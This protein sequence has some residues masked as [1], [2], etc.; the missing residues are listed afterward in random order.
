PNPQSPSETEI[1]L[2]IKGG[3][4]VTT[5]TPKVAKPISKENIAK[6]LQQALKHYQAGRFAAAEQICRKIVQS[7]PQQADALHLLGILAYEQGNKPE[8]I[9]KYRQAI[10]IKPDNPDVYNNL[11]IALKNQGDLD[12]AIVYYQQAITLRPNSADL[13]KNLGLAYKEKGLSE[14]AAA[15]YQQAITIQP[16]QADL[17]NKL[18]MVYRELGLAEE[19]IVQYQQALKLKPNWE[20]LYNNLGNA[21][22]EKGDLASAKVAYHQAIAI[23]SNYAQAQFGLAGALLMEGDF[24]RGFQGYEWRWKLKDNS[25]RKF[26]QP[27]WD[28]SSLAG[29]TILLHAEQGLGDTIQFIRY[30][31]RLKAQGARVV[32]ETQNALVELFQVLDDIDEVVGRGKPLPDFDV[33]SPLLSLSRVFG[34]TIDTIPTQVPYL[35]SPADNQL[36]LPNYFSEKNTVND[37]NLREQI[38]VNDL[39]L[40]GQ[41]SVN[42]IN[43]TEE[44]SV[45]NINFSGQDTRPTTSIKYLKVGLVWAGNPE[46]PTDYKRSSSLEYFRQL[47]DV[48]RVAFYSLQKEPGSAQLKEITEERICDLSDKLNNFADTATAI[49]QLDLVITVDTA[50]AHLAGALGKPVWVLLCY[51]ADWRWMLAREDSPWYPTMRL[52]RQSQPND[53]QGAIARVKQELQFLAANQVD[54]ADKLVKQ[55]IKAY[56]QA[57]FVEAKQISSFIL[58]SAPTKA[59]K[60]HILAVLAYQQRDFHIATQLLEKV[61]ALQPE[62]A[63]VYTHLAVFYQERGKLAEAITKF[64]QALT[65][66]PEVADTH[67]KLGV[68]LKQLGKIPE[69][70]T[71]YRRALELNPDDAT[72]H[73]NLANSLRILGKW[74][75]AEQH[76]ETAIAIDP[77]CIDAHFCLANLK[78]IQGDLLAGFAGYEYRKRIPRYNFRTFSQPV[79]TKETLETTSLQGQT[80]L[81][82]AEQGFG[83]TIQFVRYVLLLAAK[84]AKVV[85][86]CHPP[87]QKLFADSFSTIEVISQG[88]SLSDFDVQASMMSLPHIFGTT[89]TTIPNEVPYLQAKFGKN[90]LISANN[91]FKV[92]IVW[93]GNPENWSDRWRSSSL[94]HFLGLLSI[95]EIE[96]YSLQKGKA[97]AELTQYD[98]KIQDLSQQINDFADTAAIISQLDLVITVDTAVAHLAGALGKPVWTI[99]SYAPD[100]RWL[101]D[102]QDS[103]WYPTM[104]LFRQPEA[105]DWESVFTEVKQQLQQLSVTSYQLSVNSEQLPV[106]SYQSPV[107]SEQLPVNSEQLPVNSYQSSVTDSKSPIPNPQSPVT[108]PQLPRSAKFYNKRGANLKEQG[109]LAAAKENFEQAI[110]IDPN[111]AV[112]YH[113][114]GNTLKEENQLE[115]ALKQYEKAISLKPNYADAHLDYALTKLMLGDFATGFAEY[116]WRWLIV[117]NQKRD[118]TQPQWDG[119][120]LAGKTILLYGEQG[121]G[122]TIQFSRYISLVKER[123]ARRIVV[124]CYDPLVR[125]IAT[126]GGVSHVVAKGAELPNFDVQISLMSLPHIFG[127]TL[128]TVPN[129]VPYLSPL[130]EKA[131]DGENKTN[132]NLKV[133]IA[134][135]GNPNNRIDSKRSCQLK[136]FQSLLDIADV[137]FYNLQKWQS[138]ADTKQLSQ[139]PIEDLS[140]SLEDFADTANAIAKLDLVIT[141]DTAVA[142]LAGALGKPVWVLLSFAPDWRWMLERKD[143]PWY[144]TMQL[145][146]QPKAGDW[147]SVFTQ[148][149]QELQQLSVTSYQSTVTSYQLT[150]NSYQ[151]SVTSHQSTVTSQP[152]SKPK[153]LGIGW[154]LNPMLGWGVY[155]LNLTLQLIKNPNWEPFLLM[156]PAANALANPLHSLLLRPLLNQPQQLQKLIKSNPGKKI[157]CDFPILSALGNDFAAPTSALVGKKQIG[158]IFFENTRIEAEAI[159]R[160]KSYDLIV[161]GSSWNEQVLRSKGITNVTTVQQGI[162]PTIFHPAPKAN[163]LRDRFVIF[164]GGK[165]EYRKGQDIV[166]A[167]FK[168]FHNHYPE[169]LLMVAWHNFWP[170]FIRGIE[171]AGHVRGIPQVDR[172]KRLQIVDWLAH[173]NIPKDAVIDI[174]PTAN[175]LMG[176]V[177]READVALFP[178]RC[179]GG[180]NLVAMECMACGI[181]TILSANTGHLDLIQTNNCYPLHQ[182][183]KVEPIPQFPGTEGWGESDIDEIVAILETVYQNREQ[184]QQKGTQAAQFMQ[185]WT[186]E[187]QIQRLLTVFNNTL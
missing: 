8:A 60:L 182:Q 23:R 43:S 115:T 145:F 59:N 100:W 45:E 125:L 114:L 40:S 101:L 109:K 36:Y 56:R 30:V 98:V 68:A 53:W 72:I 20:V 6:S 87:L 129:K 22:R 85:L 112:A 121:F 55:A 37:V 148:V 19:A 181:P 70:V 139:L 169:A 66:Q 3:D 9:A 76:C 96:F 57:R 144:P 157:A 69:A 92:G 167:A 119:S 142:H 176:Q 152:P 163:L 63:E 99:L 132:P 143:S 187:K 13:Y 38:L 117:E 64:Q 131:P 123:G 28:G 86:E 104:R 82:Y 94:K 102:R 126:V 153:A 180:T 103:P 158:V 137:E 2:E 71:A 175:N 105:G 135:A 136:D 79:L 122:D 34:D 29:R 50:V 179:E 147:E 93:A 170:Q 44:N 18:G 161:V 90:K 164:S 151:L 51:A 177:V 106:N 174:G 5:N 1:V 150:V 58:Q 73:N 10:E 130:S 111:F 21:Y 74:S 107:T 35:F 54:S 173:N 78:L 156:P 88:E 95:P 171:R 134:W 84:G 162:E 16:E 81:V 77:D 116:E 7:E 138:E 172:N 83:D 141:V 26:P 46:N 65:L 48:N 49:S 89:L 185:N 178:N 127:T 61:I 52:F 12:A 159:A 15:A 97:A 160:A 11:A 168:K 183:S 32:V 42:D 149:K 17:Y 128:E 4:A 108:N 41:N 154:Q 80:I 24:Q 91:Q 75:E 140:N 14:Q 33:H 165:L 62:N 31:S 124:E 27:I 110:A 166:I 133:G 39:N 118:F 120:S 146:R 25:P 155:G 67:N 47:L 113:N 184:A 186:W